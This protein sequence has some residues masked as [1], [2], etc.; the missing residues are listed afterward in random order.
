MFTTYQKLNLSFRKI[1][2]SPKPV[3]FQIHNDYEIFFLLSGQ[4][5]IT[6]EQTVYRMK[7]GDLVII[8]NSEIHQDFLTEEKTGEYIEIQFAPDLLAP[9]SQTFNLYHC[10]LNRLKGRQNQ[11][12]LSKP[13]KEKIS[14]LF[15]KIENLFKNPFYAD[16]VLKYTALIE[17]VFYIN[18]LFL[19]FSPREE[20][21]NLPENLST[22]LEYIDD[23]IPN[24]LSLDILEKMFYINKSY[25]GR[26]F[27]KHL[28]VSIHEY[29][30]LQRIARAKELLMDGYN[31]QDAG[32]LSG[33]NDYSNFSKM[34]K[35][36]IHVS[37]SEYFKN[38]HDETLNTGIYRPY[39]NRSALKLPDLIVTDLVWEPKHPLAKDKLI[40]K[41][42]VKNIGTGSVPMGVILGVGFRVD[43]YTE[44]WSDNYTLGLAPGESILLDANNG[45]A[46]ISTW[47]ALSGSHQ[48][49]AHAD[50]I[51]RIEELDKDN[52]QLVK[53]LLVG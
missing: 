3:S 13:Q 38:R 31:A 28:N 32:R 37:P 7:P 33:F 39:R 27:Q 1:V 15:Q 36:V 9:F 20:R 51:G 43:G 29:I 5:S 6:V 49:V 21:L 26:L 50:D 40:F 30:V 25:L 42:V 18:R 44:T 2:V 8:N 16:E 47:N 45:Q 14:K 46:G 53:A 10:F 24:N 17:L 52:N 34:F 35:K 19:N 48:I 12:I 41:A 4:G 11:L 22:I 23:N